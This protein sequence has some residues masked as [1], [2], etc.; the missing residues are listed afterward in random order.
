MLGIHHYYLPKDIILSGYGIIGHDCDDCG[1][2]LE[3]I[4]RC[5]IIENVRIES[6]DVM[7]L[8]DKIG[9][10][11]LFSSYC[12]DR[13]LRHFEIWNVNLWALDIQN[14]YYGQEIFGAK[15]DNE[16]LIDEH[17]LE[18]LTLPAS[19]K[20]PYVLE[21]EYGY[22]LDEAKNRAWTIE[23][24]QRDDI[25]I[26]TEYHKVKPMKEYNPENYGLPVCKW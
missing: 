9:G 11:E 23:T 21:L 18:C 1:C 19:E 2:D 15:H 16:V 7:D 8:I 25:Q 13:I 26:G 14:S 22:L 24:V 4:C 3:G 17:L 5:G 6:V 12:V 10:G 20:I